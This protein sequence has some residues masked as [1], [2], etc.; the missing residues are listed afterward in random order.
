MLTCF[1]F[2]FLLT[3][4]DKKDMDTETCSD[5][6]PYDITTFFLKQLNY[7]LQN[8]YHAPLLSSFPQ[9]FIQVNGVL[10]LQF[11]LHRFLDMREEGFI[12]KIHEGKE[13]K[14]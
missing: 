6:T 2:C 7:I 10:W 8:L 13:G 14:H 4:D 1:W 3:L 11:A 12:R 5:T 9:V